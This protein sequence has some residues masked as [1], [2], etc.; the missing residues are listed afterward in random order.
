MIA[1]VYARV[2]IATL[3]LLAFATSASAELHVGAVGPR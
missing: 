1:T 2:L 3:G